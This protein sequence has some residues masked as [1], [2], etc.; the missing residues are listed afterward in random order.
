MEDVTSW[1]QKC[2]GGHRE[3]RSKAHGCRSIASL[4]S[5]S[6]EGGEGS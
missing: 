1:D 6:P 2:Y 4:V 3:E 5:S